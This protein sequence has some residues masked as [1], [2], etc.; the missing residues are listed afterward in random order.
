M[1]D[2]SVNTPSCHS[3]DAGATCTGLLS[4]GRLNGDGR[5]ASHWKDDTLTG[6]LIGLMD[7]TASGPGGVRPFQAFTKFDMIAFDAMGYDAAVPEPATWA[8]LIAGFGFVGAAARR[9]RNVAV[10][11]A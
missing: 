3:I 5:Q 10:T 8:M 6:N 2:W 7:P 4:T 11:Y 1:L 9:R